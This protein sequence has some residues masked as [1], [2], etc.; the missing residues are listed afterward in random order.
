MSYSHFLSYPLMTA[1]SRMIPKGSL[2]SGS[3]YVELNWKSPPYRPKKYTLSYLCIIRSTCLPKSPIADFVKATMLNLSPETTSIKFQALSPNFICVLR[4]KASYN[5]A[6]I[7]FG[8][9]ATSKLLAV[10]TSKCTSGWELHNNM[11]IQP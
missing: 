2:S 3:N 4:I 8:I 10:N 6:S 1:T 7:D 11:C 9:V 5:P